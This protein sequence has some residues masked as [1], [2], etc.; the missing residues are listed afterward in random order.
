MGREIKVSWKVYGRDSLTAFSLHCAVRTAVVSV[1]TVPVLL[2]TFRRNCYG[3]IQ[4]RKT[5][6]NT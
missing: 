3:T 1:G 4:D 6:T 5:A 2:Q